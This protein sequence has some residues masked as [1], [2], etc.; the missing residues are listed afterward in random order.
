MNVCHENELRVD[1][2]AM[3]VIVSKSDSWS[4][5]RAI[6]WLVYVC[7]TCDSLFLQLFKCPFECIYV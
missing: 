4:H 2:F 6:H 7:I 3:L 5:R 1:N